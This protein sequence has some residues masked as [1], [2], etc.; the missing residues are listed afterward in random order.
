MKLRHY[1]TALLSLMIVL[2]NVA[3]EPEKKTTSETSQ[4]PKKNNRF[5]KMAKISFPTLNRLK[6]M[7]QRAKF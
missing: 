5:S 2:P 1:L 6:S 3:S 4:K 7:Y